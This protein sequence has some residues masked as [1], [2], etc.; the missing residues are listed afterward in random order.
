V[1][2]EKETFEMDN[3]T[4]VSLKKLVGQT[5]QNPTGDKLGEVTDIVV[6]AV[7]GRVIYAALSVGGVL[8]M[9]EK[10]F[11]VPWHVLRIDAEHEPHVLLDASI[12][13]LKSA[14]GFEKDKWPDEA[15]AGFVER[16]HTNYS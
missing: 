7:G 3:L 14:P 2:K 5:A 16:T 6:D 12:D 9:G 1:P 11:A 4:R 10:L 8:G 15:D 13:R